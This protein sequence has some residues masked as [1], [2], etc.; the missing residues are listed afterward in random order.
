MTGLF[1]LADVEIYMKKNHTV[2]PNPVM[3]FVEFVYEFSNASHDQK[4]FGRPLLETL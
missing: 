3:C 4:R 1:A 2:D